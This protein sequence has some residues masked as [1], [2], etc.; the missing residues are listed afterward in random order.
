[1]EGFALPF[2]RR[3][4]GAAFRTGV[5]LLDRAFT[6]RRCF[7]NTLASCGPVNWRKSNKLTFNGSS[8]RRRS[9]QGN[10]GDWS[11]ARQFRP[12]QRGKNLSRADAMLL[13]S[14]LQRLSTVY[15]ARF[16][17]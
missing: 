13:G 15:L 5:V 12:F 7:A 6:A 10:G 2:S 1:M 4:A 8:R 11:V 9:S 17:Y 14:R 16:G 3:V